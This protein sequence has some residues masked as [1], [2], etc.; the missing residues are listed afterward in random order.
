MT[1]NERAEELN[2]LK[3][4]PELDR[5]YDDIR[6]EVSRD[7]HKFRVREKELSAI[8]PDQLLMM[9]INWKFRQ[10]HPR[11]RKIEVSTELSDRKKSKD[12]LRAPFE[13]EVDQLVQ[14]IA[15]GKDL[16][17]LLSPKVTQKPYELKPDIQR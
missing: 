10:I 17:H 15:L 1:V 12:A 5:L 14:M 3:D 8:T 2:R 4:S 6:T 7:L 9:Y 16:T 13:K 11:P